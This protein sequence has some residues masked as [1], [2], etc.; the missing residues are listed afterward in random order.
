MPDVN[1]RQQSDGCLKR[2]ADASH[3]T[4]YHLS[5]ATLPPP[6]AITVPTWNGQSVIAEMQANL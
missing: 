6:Y 2:E 4:R 1:I 3:M 5:S